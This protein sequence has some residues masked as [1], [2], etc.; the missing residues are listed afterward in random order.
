[1][2]PP[3]QGNILL[4]VYFNVSVITFIIIKSICMAIFLITGL[5]LIKNK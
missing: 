4:Y 2:L 5:L 1:M 3:I